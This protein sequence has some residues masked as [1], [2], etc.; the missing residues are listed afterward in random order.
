MRFMFVY[1]SRQVYNT[2]IINDLKSNNYA[3]IVDYW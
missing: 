1:T 2:F 3:K